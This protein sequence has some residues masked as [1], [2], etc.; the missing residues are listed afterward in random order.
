[1][2]LRVEPDGKLSVNVT[3][4]AGVTGEFDWRGWRRALPSGRSTFS[5]PIVNQQ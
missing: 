3:L 4:P 2:T 5:A 1:V